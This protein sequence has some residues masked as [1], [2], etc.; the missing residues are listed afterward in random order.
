[1]QIAKPHRHRGEP[2]TYCVSAERLS[3]SFVT[4]LFS[5]PSAPSKPWNGWQDGVARAA[6][7]ME[8]DEVQYSGGLFP[9]SPCCLTSTIV[10]HT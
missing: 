9:L 1:M 6:G 2:P 7:E 3:L 8:I 4:N 5:K 10:P